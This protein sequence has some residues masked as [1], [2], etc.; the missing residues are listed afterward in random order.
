MLPFKFTSSE[1]VRQAQA[2][3]ALGLVVVKRHGKIMEEPKRDPLSS[4]ES[5]E[6]IA[7]RIL[8]GSPWFS[9]PLFGFFGGP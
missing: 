6:Q 2:K 5:V 8:F 4:R 9:L 3:I 7:R 1:K